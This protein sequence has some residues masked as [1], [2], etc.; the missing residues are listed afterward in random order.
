MKRKAISLDI[1][2][3]LLARSGN[4]CAFPGCNHPIINEDNL[5]V[6]ELSHIEAVS[7]NGPRFNPNLSIAEVNSYDNLLY[8]CH[9][10]HKEIDYQPQK[11]TIGLLRKIKNEHEAQFIENPF[12][13]NFQLIFKINSEFE[14]F[15]RE[16]EYLND[17]CHVIDDLKVKINTNA[18]FF[19]IISDIKVSLDWIMKNHQELYENDKSLN[20]EIIDFLKKL[21]LDTTDFESVS[22]YDN[23]FIDRNWEPHVLGLPNFMTT[24]QVRLIQLEIKFIEEFL[25]INSDDK[26]VK[27]KLFDLKENLKMAAVSAGYID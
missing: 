25:K 5:L 10:H 1:L 4:K 8:L 16:I 11:Y 23:P 21:N 13:F 19:E 7:D 26:A 18:T 6:A 27:Q 9:R 15:W 14:H 2:K 12:Q 24:I 20:K 17:N 3:A 22:Y